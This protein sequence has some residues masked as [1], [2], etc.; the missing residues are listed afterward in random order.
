MN[1]HSSISIVKSH[2]NEN[3][4]HQKRKQSKQQRVS[5]IKWVF[6]ST[7]H[8]IIF[9]RILNRC[10]RERTDQITATIFFRTY[11]CMCTWHSWYTAAWDSLNLC[12]NVYHFASMFYSDFF[13]V[14]SKPFVFC[15]HCSG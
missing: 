11:I 7:L 4:S 6:K 2:S 13:F 5:A 12:E 10:E 15:F 14:V 3:N 1:V 9:T 8:V